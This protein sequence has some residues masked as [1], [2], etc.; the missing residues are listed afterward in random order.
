[1]RKTVVVLSP[2]RGR[3]QDDLGSDRRAPRYMVLT[4]IQPLGVLVEHGIDNVGERLVRMKKPMPPCEQI[5]FEPTD[6]SV[7]GKHLH[8]APVARKF[9]AVGILRQHL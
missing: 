3:Q 6:E 8:D 9:A 4:D 5:S 7:L 1:M 2:D